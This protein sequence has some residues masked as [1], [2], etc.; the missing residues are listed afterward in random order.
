M[1][2]PS[3]A[4]GEHAAQNINLRVDGRCMASVFTRNQTEMANGP[5]HGGQGFDRTRTL[6]GNDSGFRTAV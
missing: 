2:P 4:K 1:A 6:A 5:A 3:Q